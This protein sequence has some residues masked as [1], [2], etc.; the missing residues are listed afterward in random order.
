MNPPKSLF[1]RPRSPIQFKTVDERRPVPVAVGKHEVREKHTFNSDR[2]YRRAVRARTSLD[3][4]LK[5]AT[6]QQV[7]TVETGQVGENV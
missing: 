6:R 4:M 2:A 7:G 3:A 1:N 5:A